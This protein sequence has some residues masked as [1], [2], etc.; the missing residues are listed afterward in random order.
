MYSVRTE[1]VQRRKRPPRNIKASL[2]GA[3]RVTCSYCFER[4][5]NGSNEDQI[6]SLY[7]VFR[8]VLPFYQNL[9][10]HVGPLYV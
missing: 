1:T 10:R 5:M 6:F 2:S 8:K 9:C 7:R 4:V 3:D